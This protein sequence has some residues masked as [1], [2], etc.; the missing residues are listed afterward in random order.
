MKLRGPAQVTL[1]AGSAILLGG[2]LGLAWWSW[3]HRPGCEPVVRFRR[4][5]AAL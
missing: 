3:R 5:R 1:G 2:I 4:V